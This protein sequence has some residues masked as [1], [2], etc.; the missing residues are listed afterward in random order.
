MGYKRWKKQGHKAEKQTE[1]SIYPHK[2]K[3]V[4]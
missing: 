4:F 2:Q 1:S 3:L